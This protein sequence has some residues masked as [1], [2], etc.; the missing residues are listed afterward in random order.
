MPTAKSTYVIHDVQV[1]KLSLYKTDRTSKL[2][3]LK[4]PLEVLE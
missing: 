3:E 2:H 4:R 1:F